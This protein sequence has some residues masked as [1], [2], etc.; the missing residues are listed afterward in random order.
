MFCRVLSSAVIGIES[1]PV[2]IELDIGSGMP[3]FVMVGS[4]SAQVRESQDRVR[5]ALRNMGINIPVMK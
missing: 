3:S 5:T 4:L 1:A 2:Q